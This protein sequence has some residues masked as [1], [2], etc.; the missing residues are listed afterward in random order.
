MSNVTELSLDG[1]LRLMLAVI[2]QACQDGDKEFIL[3]DRCAKILS[4]IPTSMFSNALGDGLRSVSSKDLAL[5]LVKKIDAGDFKIK[6][7]RVV[8]AKTRKTWR[9]VH[10][11]GWVEIIDNVKEFAEEV[12]VLPSG[13]LNLSNAGGR[14]H[15]K[16]Y[17]MVRLS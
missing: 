3:G 12:G 9:V 5:S 4:F 16:G 10:P 6:K 13:L 15:Y 1:N 2:L 7:P 8:K 14:S 17:K 11:D